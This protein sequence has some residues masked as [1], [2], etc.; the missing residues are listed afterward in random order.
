MRVI[1][2]PVAALA[3]LL[4]VSCSSA[5]PA[6]DTVNDTK[7]QAADASTAGNRY[8]HLGRFDLALQF[9][10]QAL[11]LN[12]SVDNTDGIVKS[13]NSIGRTYIAMGDLDQAERILGMALPIAS[14]A[15]R[16]RLFADTTDAFAQL[17]LARGQ[18]EK[19]IAEIEKVLSVPAGTLTA[20]Q[21]A[22]LQH[23][24]GTAYKNTGNLSRARELFDTSLAVNTAAGSVEAAAADYYMIASVQSK[25]GDYAGADS[26]LQLALQMDKKM[27]NSVGI[28]KDLY[29]LGLVAAKRKDDAAAYDYFKRSYLVFTSLGL[30][31]DATGALEKLVAAAD[32][33]GE[34][35]ESA[36]Y[37]QILKDPG[38]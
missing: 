25:Q 30:T 27:E 14:A 31:A 19:A 35:P 38:K 12:T 8:M 1:C 24:L 6:S 21:T 15:G 3:L 13:Y 33:I 20:E 17:H 10:T 29:A 28:G 26:N 22:V 18:P 9:H 2:L 36:A 16:E 37:R 32:V 5:P 23:D 4:S 34:T 7:N 11:Q